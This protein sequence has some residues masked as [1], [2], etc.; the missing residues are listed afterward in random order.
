MLNRDICVTKKK[1]KV[2]LYI[3]WIE[4]V[5]LTMNNFLFIVLCSVV[6]TSA[7]AAETRGKDNKYSNKYNDFDLDSVLNNERILKSYVK[8]LLGE[9][10]CT[11]EG[12]E[13]ARKLFFLTF[14]VKM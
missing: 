11:K 10:S 4:K 5:T 8:C 14:Y 2:V 3:N 12:R 1:K 6:V 9:G 7:L 13:L